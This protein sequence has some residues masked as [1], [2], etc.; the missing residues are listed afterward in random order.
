[1]IVFNKEVVFQFQNE[2]F[3]VKWIGEV[4]EKENYREGELSFI[5]CS[6]AFLLEKNMEFLKHDT[7]TDIISFDYTIGSLVSGDIFISI[8]RV[9][10]NAA[11]FKVSFE[12]ELHRVMVHG[13]LHYCGYR[14]NE[15]DDKE[16]MRSKEDYYLSLRQF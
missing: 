16:L 3:L 5:F 9:I 4:V 15:R 8:E 2:D 14:D 11:A 6:D 1:M 12:D 10:E 7:L 13:I